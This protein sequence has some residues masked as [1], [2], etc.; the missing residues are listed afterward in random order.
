[1]GSIAYTDIDHNS[2]TVQLV[3]VGG[4][5][6]Q[7]TITA[8]S[9]SSMATSPKHLYKLRQNG[10]L[11]R[12]SDSGKFEVIQVLKNVKDVIASE[13]NFY[14][15]LAGQNDVGIA[16]ADI[17]DPSPTYA[18]LQELYKESQK[19][20]AAAEAEN[21]RLNGI[22]EESQ[23]HD[24]ADHKALAEAH[25][26]LEKSREHA[27]ALQQQVDLL[28]GELVSLKNVIRILNAK[29]A[30]AQRKQELAEAELKK[31]LNDDA[32]ENIIIEGLER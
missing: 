7:P 21:V 16:T 31:H 25:A 3:R 12:L 17:D 23:E 20:L 8:K 32:S 5:L 24:A 18:E 9:G 30:D 2:A 6:Y 1:M 29:L 26:A 22:K 4:L 27:A 11:L 13:K 15:I 28:N 10:E 19:R 14:Y